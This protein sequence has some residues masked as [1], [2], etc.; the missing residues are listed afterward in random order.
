MKI[1]SIYF[2][3]GIIQQLKNQYRVTDSYITCVINNFFK[4]LMIDYKQQLN[5]LL[6][7]Y[8]SISRVDSKNIF[9]LESLLGMLREQYSKIAFLYKPV[10][11][12]PVIFRRSYNENFI[13]DYLA[14]ILHPIDSGL[15]LE[16]IQSLL[17]FCG[18]S[19]S[20][21]EKDSGEI[22]IIRE[23]QLSEESRIDILIVFKKIKLLIGI[24]NKIFSSERHKQTIRY[25]DS[26][27]ELYPEYT[28]V[29]LY[30][31]PN[32]LKPKSSEFKQISYKE[33]L[34]ILK[35]I[36]K[37]EISP[38]NQLI[39]Q[40][41]LLHVE[42]YIMKSV[43]LKLSEKSLLY[44]KHAELISDLIESFSKDSYMIFEVISEIIKG[45]FEGAF[46]E[47]EY[48]FS[49]DRRYQQI[50]KKHW[51]TN[52]LSIHFEFHFTKE[53]LFLEPQITFMVDVEGKE[54]DQFIDKYEKYQ[55]KNKKKYQDVGIQ[56][57]PKT[58]KIAIAYKVYNFQLSPDKF[59]RSQ[60][61]LFF[62]KTIEEFLFIIVPIDQ[63]L[64]E[65]KII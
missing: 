26:I 35:P 3:V 4:I 29:L 22:Q 30:L 11:T 37:S 41:F 62:Q 53:S 36:T 56:Y 52:Q 2:V 59:D 5:L 65:N 27:Q 47:W 42:N 46:E 13:S 60:I 7:E 6:N 18:N 34:N 49:A 51:R 33:L 14:H 38:K 48:S 21:T 61:E 16:P 32:G 19:I 63:I 57:R 40:D 55:I 9:A 1:K 10:I 17:H 50:W 12:I 15:G 44:L 64:T 39:Y 43:N 20:L 31:T 54:K 23:H 58:R 24:E 28:Q 25:S 45:I 8:N